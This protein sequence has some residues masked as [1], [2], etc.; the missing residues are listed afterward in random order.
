MVGVDWLRV[1]GFL[2]L[3]VA[4][5]ELAGRLKLTGLARA[6]DARKLNHPP[7]LVGGALAF[8]WAPEPVARLSAYVGMG[9]G[10]VLLLVVC[11]YRDRPPFRTMFVG[12][13]RESD[14]PHE[15]FHVWFSW[16]VSVVG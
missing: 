1:A 15:C 4:V 8:G 6:G 2:G 16:L 10:F 12:Y 7:A 3:V 14:A 13:A 5:W 9:A 11:R